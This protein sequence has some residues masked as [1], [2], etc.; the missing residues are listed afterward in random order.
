M[1]LKDRLFSSTRESLR[2]TS[3]LADLKRLA[4]DTLKEDDNLVRLDRERRQRYFTKEDTQVLDSLKKRLARRINSFLQSSGKGT[5]VTTSSLGETSK[6]EKLPEIPIEDPP[7]F[8]EIVS[9]SPKEVYPNKS[10]SIKFKTDAHPNYFARAET[11]VAFI[12]P[13]SFGSFTG[14]ARVN[15]GYGMAYFKANEE[16]EIGEKGEITLELRPPK[17][18][19]ITDSIEIVAVDSPENSDSTGDGKNKSPNIQVDF[20]DKNHSFYQDN[21]WDDTNVAFVADDQE[22]VFIFVSEENKN[23]NKLVSKAQ[24]NN[25]LAV[26]N[27]KN[28]YLEH[29]SFYAFMLDQNKPE[30]ILTEE[31]NTISD[32][33]FQKIKDAELRNASET[34]CGMINDFF[35]MIIIESVESESADVW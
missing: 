18:K 27:I 16:T 9:T 15:N 30:K 3:I 23:L 31:E 5:T 26:Q 34:V 22:G 24:R 2:D 11:F 19:S 1:I 6:A 20:I 32:D 29:I 8:F 10:F 33:T 12:D 14:T 13:Q 35:E 28:K 4:I 21:N 25:D 7:T 17:L